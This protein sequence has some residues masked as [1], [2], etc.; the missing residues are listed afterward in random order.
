MERAMRGARSRTRSFGR[1]ARLRRRGAVALS[2]VTL[3]FAGAPSGKITRL[4]LLYEQHC[5]GGIPALFGEIRFHEPA[6]PW[7]YFAAS[8]HVWFPDTSVGTTSTVVPVY[9]VVRPSVAAATFGQARVRGADP[10][11]FEVPVD[12]CDGTTV[13]PGSFC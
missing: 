9:V 8:G 4:D 2:A 10:S 12:A 13:Q 11:D 3:M 6:P 1:A 5:E 7:T